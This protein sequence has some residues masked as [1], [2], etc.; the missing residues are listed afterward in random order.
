[1]NT[2]G[3]QDT[4]RSLSG[5]RWIAAGRVAWVAFALL[6]LFLFTRG[7]PVVVHQ[8]ENCAGIK[9]PITGLSLSPT[10]PPSASAIRLF[11]AYVVVV[12]GLS[13][14]ILYALSIVLLRRQADQRI[15]LVA[16][17]MLIGFTGATFSATIDS[18]ATLG[19]AWHW[20]TTFT[21]FVGSAAIMPFLCL[22]PDGRF[23]PRWT[24]WVAGIWLLVC[25]VG[26]YTPPT[27]MLSAENTNSSGMPIIAVFFFIAVVIAQVKRYR[28]YAS[29]RQRQQI[30]WVVGG[31]FAALTCLLIA[32]LGPEALKLNITSLVGNAIGDTLMSIALLMI[33][34]AIVMA[35]VKTQLW[36]IDR[37]I[38]R[39]LVYG[40]LSAC[41][42]GVYVGAVLL[43]ERLFN[44]LTGQSDLAIALSTLVVAALFNPARHRIQ[45]IVDRRFYR[46]KYDA[47]RALTHFALA[48]R[49]EV[50]L[51][52]LAGALTNIIAETV[53]P[54]HLSVWLRDMEVEI[55]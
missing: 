34:A 9:C 53:Q 31:L 3:R 32:I 26:Y 35:I 39:A 7:V 46:Q 23:V 20:G 51:E 43:F 12:E 4:Q 25:V 17:F 15:A 50:D 49:E 38:N 41:L 11:A 22:L 5:S 10:A 8:I 16:A 6:T 21:G 30:K 42:I 27:P 29:P 44:P 55:R 13:L 19:G 40:G 37:I 48:A 54:E 45:A 52:R 14:L 33:P 2:P 36:D 1:M 47:E 28:H 24:R 18:T